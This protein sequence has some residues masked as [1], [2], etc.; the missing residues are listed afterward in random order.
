MS[1]KVLI[2]AN[3]ISGRGHD[4]HF[5]EGLS[6]ALAD[7]GY[8]IRLH[9]TKCRRD[10]LEVAA[11]A[12]EDICAVLSV[13]GD[14]THNEVIHGLIGRDIPLAVVPTGTENVLG[15]SLGIDGEIATAVDMVRRGESALIDV[16]RMNDRI[17]VMF[18]GVGYDAAVTQYVHRRRH[19]PIRRSVYYWPAAKLWWHYPFTP[20]AVTIDGKKVSEKGGMVVVGNMALYAMQLGVVPDAIP[21]DGLLDVCIYECRSR[22][23]LLRH[24]VRTRFGK[25]IGQR[26]V[27]HMRGKRIEVTSSTEVP[28]EVDG[29]TVGYTPAIYTVEPAAVRLLMPT[30]RS[31]KLREQ[32]NGQA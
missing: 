28:I 2:I 4:P 18:S 12:E 32:C 22:W 3:P 21:D 29:D 6:G 9:R 20:L 26:D 25:H 27:I 31:K 16:G 23:T 13:G 14:G 8:D 24:F 10:A 15:R 17:F 5:L 11:G 19:G 1:E 30:G 7:A